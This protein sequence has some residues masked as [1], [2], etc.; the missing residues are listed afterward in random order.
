MLRQWPA[1]AIHA[2]TT[3]RGVANPVAMFSPAAD[4]SNP[5]A[6]ILAAKLA[7]WVNRR[8]ATIASVHRCAARSRLRRGCRAG[9]WRWVRCWL[10]R[11]TTAARVC[12]R[13]AA[14]AGVVAFLHASWARALA[15]GARQITAAAL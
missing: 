2:S 8:E 11:Q 15:A 10:I 12:D 5:A 1:L 14:M 13:V 9:R 6:V 4:Q 3:S 7:P